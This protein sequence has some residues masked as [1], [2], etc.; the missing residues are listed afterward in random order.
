ME[1]PQPHADLVSARECD[2][3]EALAALHELVRARVTVDVLG[4]ASDYR[5][6]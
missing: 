3:A 6:R 5:F 2:F 4:A 1:A